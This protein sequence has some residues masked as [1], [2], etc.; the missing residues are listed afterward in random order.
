MYN[1]TQKTAPNWKIPSLILCSAILWQSA[2]TSLRA[3]DSVPTETTEQDPVE[4]TDNGKLVKEPKTKPRFL[5]VVDTK[6]KIEYNDR[7]LF[8]MAKNIYHE[9]GS[10]STLGKYAI[11][12]VTVNRMKHPQYP[13]GICEVVLQPYQFSWA[14]NRSNRWNSPPASP[15]WEK[16]KEIAQD[17]L[18]EGKRVHGLDKAI[19]F[20]ASYM[21]PKWARAKHRLTKIGGHIFYGFRGK[22][23]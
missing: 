20:H 12:Q 4:P 7:D 13:D 3:A 9:A 23:G 6:E 2:N 5:S 15:A 18:T 16:S 10:E 14:N 22:A 19:F 21:T 11:A 17:V 8:C 1:A